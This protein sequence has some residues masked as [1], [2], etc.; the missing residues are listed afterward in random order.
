[1]AGVWT[2]GQ[3]LLP[4]AAGATQW[5]GSA[6]HLSGSRLFVGAPGDSNV[7][8]LG[9]AVH[10][11]DDAGGTFAWTATFRAAQPTQFLHL[12]TDVVA[13]GSQVLAGSEGNA[14]FAFEELLGS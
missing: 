9:G 12:G 7:A 3:T 4:P 11:Y 5:F 1:A 6:V 2:E 8:N 14:V 10:V 13:A